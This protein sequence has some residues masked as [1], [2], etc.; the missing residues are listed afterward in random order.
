MNRLRLV[1]AVFLSL[2]LLLLVAYA[3]VIQYAPS[4]GGDLTAQQKKGI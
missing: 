2:I 3:V 4:F 1:L